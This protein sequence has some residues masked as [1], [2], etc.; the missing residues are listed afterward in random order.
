M[1]TLDGLGI[2]FHETMSGWVGVG[3]TDYADGLAK[4]QAQGTSLSVDLTISIADLGRFLNI[5]NHMADLTGTVTFQP[6]G[7]AV[8]IRDGLFNLFSVDPKENLRH[9]TYSFRFTAPNGET[10]FLKGFKRIRDDPGFDL[11]SD[12]TTLFTTVYAGEDDA[13]VPYA[14]GEVRFLLKDLPAL[15]L[16]MTVTGSASLLQQIEAKVAFASFA[17]GV[18]R[19]E[20]LRFINPLYDTK[21]QNL[22]LSG[23]LKA[24]SGESTDFFLVSGLHDKDFPWGDGE[25]FSDVLLVIADGNQR[26]RKFCITDRTLPGQELYVEDGIYR[27]R[28]PLFELTDGYVAS[29]SQMRERDPLLIEWQAD[30]E[31]GFQAK[32]FDT[33]PLPFT[34]AN[35]LIAKLSTRLKSLFEEVL[36]S[37]QFLGVY[38]TPH[39]VTVQH[40][41]LKLQK[42]GRQTSDF[43]IQPDATFGEAER[44]TIRNIKEPTMLYG[45]ICAVR[46]D[47]HMARVQIHADSLRNERQHWLKDQLDAVLG[48]VVSQKIRV[49][50][51]MENDRL[52]VNELNTG[53]EPDEQGSLPFA[54]QGSPILQVDNDHFPTAIF[55]RRIIVGKD[56][57][58]ATCLALEEAMDIMRVE[59][60]NSGK[61][62]KV[63]AITHDDKIAALETVLQQTDFWDILDTA[64]KK[65]GK[66]RAEFSIIIKPNFMFAYN[67]AD[68]TTY[69]DP[70]LVE[71][72]TRMLA[73]AG[74]AKVFVVEAHS[75]YGEFFDNRRVEDLAAYLGY[76]NDEGTYKLVDLTEDAYE[77]RHFGPKLGYHRVPLTWRDADF[78][79]SFA[80]NKTHAYAYYTLT[81]KNVYGAL[82]LGNKFKEYHCCRDI[83]QTTIEYLTAFPVD[84]GLVDAYSSAD[85]PFGIFADGAPNDTR[86]IIGGAD[87]VAVDWVAATKMGLDPMVS[88][89]MRFAVAAFG[90]PRIELLGDRSLYHPWLN[91]PRALTLFTNYGLDA[92][93]Y[94]GSLFYMSGAYMDTTHF[95]FKD[96]GT[97]VRAARAVLGPLQTALFLQPG[98]EQSRLNK[99]LSR[100]LT[101]LG[102]QHDGYEPPKE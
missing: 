6:L 21:Y 60:I 64:C 12:M 61:Q 43:S 2:E 14:A 68:H 13:A 91:V 45:Y 97:F 55:Q 92:N 22:V 18:L 1:G 95:H 24:D 46:P 3:E 17:Y 52:T 47:A 20:Y 19:D 96:H 90:K 48:A 71:H 9:M 25:I 49:E 7:R 26:Y 54:Q 23:K 41:T 27:Y 72:L 31:I 99:A 51:L 76:D 58:A 8:P 32:P 100:F 11:M 73:Q 75:T 79:I 16:S 5:A 39:T 98:G 37:E 82:P 69:T 88:A 15:L 74:Y 35:D 34:R 53:Q 44:S 70:E 38:I 81:L 30:F 83:Y 67:V 65:K 63:A 66:T 94:F 87:L 85:G 29:F 57:S 56:P 84:F 101:W 78:R 40:G 77:E 89:Y 50:M 4:G 102:D 10:Y 59:P 36:P 42:Q 62:V 86:T 80:K 28:G 33:T 93:Y